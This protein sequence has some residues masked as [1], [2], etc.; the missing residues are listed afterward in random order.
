MSSLAEFTPP[1]ASLRRDMALPRSKFGPLTG[2]FD[3]AANRPG[4]VIFA[5]FWVKFLFIQGSFWD[6]FQSVWDR[7]GV[8]LGPFRVSFGPFW[9]HFGTILGS[10][11][12]TLDHFGVILG[13]F[14]GHFGTILGSFWGLKAYM[15]KQAGVRRHAQVKRKNC[16]LAHRLRSARMC[17]H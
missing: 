10:F 5:I 8:L 11:W 14:W 2:R 3:L 16:R 9:G 12:V 6:H 1:G 4:Q 13:P 15:H 17:Q 7:F